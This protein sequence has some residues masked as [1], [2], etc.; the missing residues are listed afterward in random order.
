[1]KGGVK[2]FN[3]MNERKAKKLYAFIDAHP[4]FYRNTIQADSR[5]RMNVVFN[6][7]N[8]E[9]TQRFLESSHQ[10]RVG[11]I[12]VVIGFLVA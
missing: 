6:L 4:E 2:Y 3:D 5:S 11:K 10:S 9:L 8:D 7:N 1:M 12:Y